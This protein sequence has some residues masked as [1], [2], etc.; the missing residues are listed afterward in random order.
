M[1]MEELINEITADL[2]GELKSAVDF[3]PTVLRKKVESAANE[4]KR[5]RRYPESYTAEEITADLVRFSSNIRNI[6]L[7][8]Y[9][10]IGAEFQSYSGEGAIFRNFTDRNK[11]FYGV[12]P[13]AICG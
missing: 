12:T 7:Y 10:Q 13:F 4:V 2:T 11:L 6:A 9:N 1:E 8:D 3:S 5:A